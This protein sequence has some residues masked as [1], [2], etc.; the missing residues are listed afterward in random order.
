MDA[1]KGNPQRL[2]NNHF[3]AKN[4][5]WSPDGKRIAFTSS[6]DG[7]MEIYV[8]DADGN[9]QQNLTNRPHLDWEPSWSPDG[10]RIAFMSNGEGGLEIKDGN[11]EIYVMDAD[12]S[13]Q[14]N[15]TNN[16]RHDTRSLMVS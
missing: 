2:T 13:N 9:N 16:R 12:G 15:L 7:N 10:K 6:R 11:L 4:P 5:S 1:D 8:M 3:T 14:R